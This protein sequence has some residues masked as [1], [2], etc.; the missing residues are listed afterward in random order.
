MQKRLELGNGMNGF[1]L[2]G[3]LE[4]ELLKLYEKVSIAF[5]DLECRSVLG[6]LSVE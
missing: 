3:G 5:I 6:E 1:Q 4:S 2:Y